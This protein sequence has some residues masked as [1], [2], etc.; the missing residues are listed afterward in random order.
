ME[1]REIYLNKNL[2]GLSQSEVQRINGIFALFPEVLQAIIYGSRAKGNY[3]PYSDI[4]LTLLG[5][6]LS[7][8]DLLNIEL[9]LD[10]LLLPYVFDLSLKKQIS[11]TDLIDHINRV[12]KLFYEKEIDTKN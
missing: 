3:K 4:D 2:F 7:K 9:Q 6:N 11:N 1:N 5:D 8:K 10:D 12:G